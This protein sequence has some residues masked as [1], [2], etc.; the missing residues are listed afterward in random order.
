MAA[1]SAQRAADLRSPKTKLGVCQLC[2]LQRALIKAH[3]I[4]K[5]FI[6]YSKLGDARPSWIYSEGAYPQRTQNGIY[7]ME[8]VCRAC[9]NI[10]SRLDDYGAKILLPEFPDDKCEMLLNGRG[11]Y[12]GNAFDYAKLKL[13]ILSVLW[14]ASATKHPFY[15]GISLGPHE[16]QI[17]DMVK[18]NNPGKPEQY[19]VILSRFTDPSGHIC[20]T[21][22]R[23]KRLPNGRTVNIL[24][25][26]GYKIRVLVDSQEAPPEMGPFVLRPDL[27]LVV[28]LEDSRLCP[29]FEKIKPLVLEGERMKKKSSPHRKA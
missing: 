7:D 9:E 15:A 4:P 17:A 5:S 10:F 3:I 25:F 20:V 2:G 14:R 6:E 26:G 16:K 11:L 24:Y 18:A 28:A 21:K 1:D 23:R 27:P 19:S 12:R 13:F 29:E 22:P 8:L